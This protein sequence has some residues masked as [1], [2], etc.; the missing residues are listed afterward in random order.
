LILYFVKPFDNHPNVCTPE[1][2][3]KYAEEER[4]GYWFGENQSENIE[5]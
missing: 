4:E 2:Y 1:E 3:K 5:N